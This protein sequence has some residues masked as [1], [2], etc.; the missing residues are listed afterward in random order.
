VFDL[1]LERLEAFSLMLAGND[2]RVVVGVLLRI[3]I[4]TRL[5]GGVESMLAGEAIDIGPVLLRLVD[6]LNRLGSRL[7]RPVAHWSIDIFNRGSL[8]DHLPHHVGHS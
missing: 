3:L 4:L 5:D 2:A 6:G 1:A 7:L 8:E